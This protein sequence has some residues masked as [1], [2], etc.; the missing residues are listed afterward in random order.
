M[1]FTL[2]IIILPTQKEALNDEPCNWIRRQYLK[3]ISYE[4]TESVRERIINDFLGA[5]PSKYHEKIRK[6][7][8]FKLF[9]KELRAPTTFNILFQHGDFTPNNILLH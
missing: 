5:W 8:N 4:N 2:Y 1:N 6:L 9:E 7:D 3:A